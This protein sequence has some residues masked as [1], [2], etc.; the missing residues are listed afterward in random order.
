MIFKFVLAHL[1]FSGLPV[2][3]GSSAPFAG[4][5]P[6]A[7]LILESA[8]GRATLRW[9][10]TLPNAEQELANIG[11]TSRRGPVRMYL[12]EPVCGNIHVNAGSVIVISGDREGSVSF[13]NGVMDSVQWKNRV[14]ITRNEADAWLRD[15]YNRYGPADEVSKKTELQT[16]HWRKPTTVLTVTVAPKIAP[17]VDD[18]WTVAELYK[19]GKS[20]KRDCQGPS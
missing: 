18:M 12:R 10:M 2:F 5:K 20:N 15:L 4:E 19:R 17:D 7:G 1:I 14:P 6:S 13:V 8:K 16:H 9:D 11:I 3:A